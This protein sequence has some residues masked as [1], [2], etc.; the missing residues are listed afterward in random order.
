MIDRVMIDRAATGRTGLIGR[1]R[2]DRPGAIEMIAIAGD[3]A[4]VRN[5]RATIVAIDV[6]TGAR[7]LPTGV[8]TAAVGLRSGVMIAAADHRIG[9]TRAAADHQIGVTIGPANHPID[10][11]SGNQR[12]KRIGRGAKSLAGASRGQG[13][14]RVDRRR[15]VVE[16]H[17]ARHPIAARNAMTRNNS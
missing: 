1:G 6:T 16:S 5:V 13:S 10:A 7:D 12:V 15:L 17:F 3:G 4:T 11:V 14:Q 8:T 2:S 9:A